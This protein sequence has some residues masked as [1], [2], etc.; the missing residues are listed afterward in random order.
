M[1]VLVRLVRAFEK[2][3]ILPCFSFWREQF[4]DKETTKV[5][6]MGLGDHVLYYSLENPKITSQLVRKRN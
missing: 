1:H 3:D 6:A 5:T 2:I 4:L